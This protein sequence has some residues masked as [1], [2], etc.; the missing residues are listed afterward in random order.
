[1][2]IVTTGANLTYSTGMAGWLCSNPQIGTCLPNQGCPN[3]SAAEG[4][5]FYTNFTSTNHPGAY[6]LTG[7]TECNGAEGVTTGEDPDV[8]GETGQ[9]AIEN[10]MLL[11]CKNP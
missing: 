7:I 11:S 1:M 3:N 4:N 2:S 5:Y 10:H 6:S 8:P 9:T